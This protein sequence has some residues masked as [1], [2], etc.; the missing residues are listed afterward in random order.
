MKSCDPD[1][2]VPQKVHMGSTQSYIAAAISRSLLGDTL[3]LARIPHENYRMEQPR[4]IT[5]MQRLASW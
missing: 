2:K 4:Q 5:F 3:Q 1:R